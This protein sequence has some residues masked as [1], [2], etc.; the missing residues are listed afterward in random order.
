[1]TF[2]HTYTTI[3]SCIFI[4]SSWKFSAEVDNFILTTWGSS[5]L[6]RLYLARVDIFLSTLCLGWI[7][8]GV[9]LLGEGGVFLTKSLQKEKHMKN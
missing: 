2:A 6:E 4:M 3:L 9:F 8:Q 5:V 7:I 1:M